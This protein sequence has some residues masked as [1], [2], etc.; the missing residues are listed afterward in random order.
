MR[1]PSR[2]EWAIN[3]GLSPW[4][5]A[6]LLYSYTLLPVTVK[7]TNRTPFTLVDTHFIISD[8]KFKTPSS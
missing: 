5:L 2:I 8:S 3:A 4:P 1:L 6:F 7:P